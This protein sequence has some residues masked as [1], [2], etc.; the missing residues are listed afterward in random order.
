MR[1]VT[2]RTLG[3]LE[4]PLPSLSMTGSAHLG[5]RIRVDVGRSEAATGHFAKGDISHTV[6]PA[7]NDSRV[8]GSVIL[9]RRISPS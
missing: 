2:A 8:A 3:R 5:R 4:R 7:R 6:S 9:R 1:R